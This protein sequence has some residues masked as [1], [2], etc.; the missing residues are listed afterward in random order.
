MINSDGGVGSSG[1]RD[2][3]GTVIQILNDQM[4]LEIHVKAIQHKLDPI[5]I[6]MIKEEIDSRYL[7][8][9]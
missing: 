8:S 6:N 9:K 1:K 2:N 4:L 5:F 3:S 7:E